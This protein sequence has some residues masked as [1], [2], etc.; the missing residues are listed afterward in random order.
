MVVMHPDWNFAAACTDVVGKMLQRF[1]KVIIARPPMAPTCF[2]NN[3]T[4]DT[5]YYQQIMP[6]T[7]G[8]RYR[9]K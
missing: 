7:G 6:S 4:S 2:T 8:R 5:F 3:V 9:E 1:S